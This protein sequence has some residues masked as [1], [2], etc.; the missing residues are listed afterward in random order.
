MYDKINCKITKYFNTFTGI[1]IVPSVC[2]MGI[3]SSLITRSEENIADEEL[4]QSSHSTTKAPTSFFFS[5]MHTIIIKK[6]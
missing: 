3:Q 1:Q 2:E 6:Y 5:F 4:S